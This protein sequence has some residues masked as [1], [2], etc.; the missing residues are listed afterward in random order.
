MLVDGGGGAVHQ[1]WRVGVGPGNRVQV[2]RFTRGA[3]KGA[4]ADEVA[5]LRGVMAAA[6]P[7]KTLL[8]VGAQRAAMIE[9]DAHKVI[10][11][12]AGQ[13]GGGHAIVCGH[14]CAHALGVVDLRWNAVDR[15]VR[16]C[17]PQPLFG[18]HIHA[19]LISMGKLKNYNAKRWHKDTKATKKYKGKANARHKPTCCS[20]LR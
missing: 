16:Q 7:V 6:P 9:V 18:G 2:R 17:A 19:L 10:A 20:A 8:A 12:Q 5:L 13:V 11:K 1:I 14:G 15:R 3:G 4:G